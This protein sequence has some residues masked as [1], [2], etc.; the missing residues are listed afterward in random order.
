M[1][2]ADEWDDAYELAV[3]ENKALPFGRFQRSDRNAT[4]H[5]SLR[6]GDPCKFESLF[7][8]ITIDGTTKETISEV[9][10]ADVADDFNWQ[11]ALPGGPRSI[12]TKFYYF[13]DGQDSELEKPAKESES[14]RKDVLKIPELPSE[15]EVQ[16][17]NVT[18]CPYASWCCL[19]YTSPSPRDRTRSRMPS[20]A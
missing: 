7:R 18:H 11:S 20:S 10:K 17:H 5:R 6:Q 14:R 16:R 8:R 1:E 9:F 19:L 15:E 2:Y 3:Q 4:R 12:I 13:L